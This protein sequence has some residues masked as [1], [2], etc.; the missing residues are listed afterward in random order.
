MPAATPGVRRGDGHR[1]ADLSYLVAWT[2]AY[3]L[4]ETTGVIS[5]GSCMVAFLLPQGHGVSNRC[6]V[7]G[8]E[9]GLGFGV[10]FVS[11]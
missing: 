7:K 3:I 1:G 6:V 9:P 2:G 11:A 4:G 8:V 10:R 5:G